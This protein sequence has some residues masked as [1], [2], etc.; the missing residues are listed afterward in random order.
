MVIRILDKNYY[1]LQALVSETGVSQYVCKNVAEDDGRV[2]RVA[3]LSRE[4]QTPA[5]IRWLYDIYRTGCFR[6]LV[7]YSHESDGLQIV[8]DCGPETAVPVSRLLQEEK[9]SLRERVKMGGELLKRLILS[10]VPAFFAIS[11]LDPDHVRFTGSLDCF[12]TF[13]LGSLSEYYRA[14]STEEFRRLA[15]VFR[16]LFAE[17]IRL[18][19]M[20]ELNAF[21]SRIEQQEFSSLRDIYEAWLPIVEQYREAE[22]SEL[23]AKSLPFRIWD[24]IMDGVSLLKSLVF[25]LAIG[26]AIAYLVI[27]V[28]RFARPTEQ[29]DVYEQVGDLTIIIRIDETA[30]GADEQLQR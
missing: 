14:D 19:K 15:S 22:S 25:I 7:Q 20:P 8:L 21:L 16:S 13:E 17:E 6:E 29:K 12:L 3:L 9:P 28:M 30:E 24:R 4:Q 1:V 26:L 5:L 18:W 10:D 2:Y 23:A 27:S 11:A